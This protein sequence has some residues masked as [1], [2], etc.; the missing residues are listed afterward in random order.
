MF[1]AWLVK[2]AKIAAS[3]APIVLPGKRPR[4][5]V[6]V[7]DKNP[8]IGTDCRMSSAGRITSSARRLLA[9]SVATTKVKMS[10]A[11]IAANMRKVVRSAYSGSFAGSRV[12]CSV[13]SRVTGADHS[14]AP[15]A[16]STKTPAIRT[17]IAIS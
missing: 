9:A 16:S 17:K 2:M 12:T 6:T 8:R 10:E 15:C 11:K 4:K 14:C 1:Q 13:D 3:S 7:K 5:N